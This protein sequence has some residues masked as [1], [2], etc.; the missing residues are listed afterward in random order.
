MKTGVVKNASIPI[1]KYNKESNLSLLQDDLLSFLRKVNSDPETLNKIRGSI[2]Y[3]KIPEY[4]RMYKK[5]PLYVGESP[6]EIESVF[7]KENTK[8]LLLLLKDICVQ[9]LGYDSIEQVKPD[10]TFLKFPD[11][12]YLYP[13]DYLTYFEKPRIITS[14]NSNVTQRFFNYLLMDWKIQE[15]PKYFFNPETNRFEL[16]QSQKFFSRDEIY[17]EEIDSIR[18]LVPLKD[19]PKYFR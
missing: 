14:H 2:N 5:L 3:N 15:S 9:Y 7:G 12:Y 17:Q 10:G 1:E 19:R 6:F 16:E 13:K 11:Y 4:I 18:R 8:N